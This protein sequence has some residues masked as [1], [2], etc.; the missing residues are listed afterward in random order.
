MSI[1]RELWPRLI[2]AGLYGF[3]AEGYWLDI[4]TPARYL[5]GTFDII[6]GNVATAVRERLGDSYLAIAE[7]AEVPAARSRRPCSSAACRSPRAPMSAAWS[8]SGEDVRVGAGSSVERAV[9]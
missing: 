1:E 5:Q 2:G 4:G 7:G 6:E 8:C 9:V 3:P